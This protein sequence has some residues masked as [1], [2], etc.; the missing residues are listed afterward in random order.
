M[1]WIIVFGF[2]FL[3]NIYVVVIIKTIKNGKQMFAVFINDLDFRRV[4]KR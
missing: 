2:F 3:I 1:V 4:D